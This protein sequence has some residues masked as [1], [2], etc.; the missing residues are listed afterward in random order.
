MS[1][2]FRI[3]FQWELMGFYCHDR[4]LTLTHM[5]SSEYR[6]DTESSEKKGGETQGK[7]TEDRKTEQPTM[8]VV[9]GASV[10]LNH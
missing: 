4:S 3:P 2:L 8:S 7:A 5:C 6:Q 9:S 10:E 1:V